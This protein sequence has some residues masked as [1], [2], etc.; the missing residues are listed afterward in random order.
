VILIYTVGAE[1]ILKIDSR[2][3]KQDISRI[4]WNFEL[5]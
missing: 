1:R 2:P 3:R 4:L 5:W